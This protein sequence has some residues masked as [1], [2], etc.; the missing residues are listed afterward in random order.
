MCATH[1]AQ[2][3]MLVAAILRIQHV[4]LK[5]V[6][7]PTFVIPTALLLITFAHVIRRI[8]VVVLMN[9]IRLV[10]TTIPQLR[11]AVPMSVTRLA[12]TMIH[13]VLL[14]VPM[15]AIRPVQT[16]TRVLVAT[17]TRRAIPVSRIHA[18][19]VAL[20]IQYQDVFRIATDGYYM[21]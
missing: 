21:A 15:S 1:L 14:A 13:Q 9:A 5:V 19:L 3:M 12:K 16:M 10:R 7:V 4:R 2:T 8:Q 6:H 11:L 20:M 18:R 17:R